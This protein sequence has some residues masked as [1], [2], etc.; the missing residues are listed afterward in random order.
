MRP[1][2]AV[3]CRSWTC[4]LECGC[5]VLCLSPIPITL[6]SGVCRRVAGHAVRSYGLNGFRNI[7]LPTAI[8]GHDP[9]ISYF[10]GTTLVIP[11][12]PERAGVRHTVKF[13]ET[14]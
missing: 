12:P 2:F 4:R 13:S 8:L 9:N 5:R 3:A 10:V 7:G 1:T 11:G 6:G 14:K